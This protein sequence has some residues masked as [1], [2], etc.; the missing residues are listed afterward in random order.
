MSAENDST[1]FQPVY[2]ECWE[3]HICLTCGALVYSPAAGVH[4]EWHRTLSNR[5]S[6]EV[7]ED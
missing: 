5:P 3:G 1:R 4:L 7:T 2:F 6:Y